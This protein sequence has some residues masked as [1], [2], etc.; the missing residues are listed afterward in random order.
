[1]IDVKQQISSVTRTIGDRTLQAGE[2]R[3]MTISQVYP[4][5]IDDLWEVVTDSARIERWFAPVTGDLK[6]GGRYQVQ[7]NAGGTI[8]SC[9][10]PRGYA[11]TWEFGGEVS[12]IEVRLT[13]EGDGTRF[14]LEH[15]AH[16]K[17]EFWDKYGPGATGIGWE[18][19]LYG[20][21]NHLADPSAPGLSPEQAN[22]WA[23]SDDGKWLIRASS[24]GWAEAAVAWGDD[25][26]AARRRADNCFAF[27]TGAPH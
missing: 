26:E 24:D 27:Y 12:W 1:M 8:T 4:T 13:P 22:E 23:V 6:E 5:D 11:A 7:G 2:A 25:A 9:D 3:V 14:H 19:G 17:D 21:A 16:V 15:V 10:R 20:L 18:L